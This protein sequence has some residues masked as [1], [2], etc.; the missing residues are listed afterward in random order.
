MSSPAKRAAV[1]YQRGPRTKIQAVSDDYNNTTRTITSDPDSALQQKINDLLFSKKGEKDK[2]NFQPDEEFDSAYH[3]TSV[4]AK[5]VHDL[6][7]V[8]ET[9][10]FIDEI[11]YLL[12]GLR[13]TG[14]RSLEIVRAS[15]EEV[16][17]KCFD[18]AGVVNVAFGMKLKAHGALGIIFECLNC[19][20]DPVILDN[21]I[22]LICGLLNDV[23]RL[24][25]FFK[26]E[27]AIKLARHCLL[28]DR[29][30][31][32][33]TIFDKLKC[34]QVLLKDGRRD[35][36]QKDMFLHVGIWLLY[37]WTFSSVTSKDNAFFHLLLTEIDLLKKSVQIV[38]RND[39][40][41]EKSAGFLDC[42][43]NNRKSSIVNLLEDDLIQILQFI[44]GGTEVSPSLICMKLAVSITGSSIGKDLSSSSEIFFATVKDL[45]KIIGPS[46][47]QIGILSIS[48]LI[49][50]ID[51]CDDTVLDE[52]RYRKMKSSEVTLLEYIVNEMMTP[53]SAD[54][55]QS[56]DPPAD[57][58][59]SMHKSL[60]AL[61][62]GFICRQNRTNLQVMSANFPSDPCRQQVKR[63]IV[64]VASNFALKIGADDDPESKMISERLNE[65]IS[66]FK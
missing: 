9:R 58:S 36:N 19:Y 66:T 35:W 51:R 2:E 25:F 40:I 32:S 46:C 4:N 56:A 50:L 17:L 62:L 12:D 5:K 6:V 7:Q 55:S 14:P 30:L 34:T 42:L 57:D 13:V 37:K 61:L 3:D 49:N 63:E 16:T 39:F 54:S 24:D 43:L 48:C 44:V 11:E 18:S 8:G 26:P 1:T 10:R 47:T 23:R 20:Q 41:G 31:I 59:A 64:A 38:K 33:F 21:L 45:L 29:E 28:N 52:F 15:L 53:Q 60:L 65:I 22:L 27:L